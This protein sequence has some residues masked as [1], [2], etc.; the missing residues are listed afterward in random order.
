MKK[1]I[2]VLLLFSGFNLSAF[3]VYGLKSGMTKT[4]FYELTGCQAAVEKYNRENTYTKATLKWCFDG[5]LS[6]DYFEDINPSV[7]F[8]WTHE[9]KLWRVSLQHRKPSGILKGIAFKKAVQEAHPGMEV[10]ESSST[11][12]YGTVEYLIVT[13]IDESLSNSSINHYTKSF[14]EELNNKK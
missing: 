8:Q 11:N 10:V 13:Y 7:F 12:Q 5:S 14:L 1:L 6:L 9:D 4:E 2:L 3:E